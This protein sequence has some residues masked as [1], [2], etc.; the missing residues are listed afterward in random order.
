[1][2]KNGSRYYKVVY[3]IVLSCSAAKLKAQIAWKEN[4]IASLH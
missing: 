1:M 3:D 2:G 4:V